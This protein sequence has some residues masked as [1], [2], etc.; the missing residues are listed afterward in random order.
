MF[1]DRSRAAVLTCKQR[2][3]RS[4]GLLPI[5]DYPI[6]S[7]GISP[8]DSASAE[9][10]QRDKSLARDETLSLLFRDRSRAGVLLVS[11]RIGYLR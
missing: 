7:A 4:L 5:L 9:G 1:R 11:E 3:S 2:I 10:K 8:H 6:R